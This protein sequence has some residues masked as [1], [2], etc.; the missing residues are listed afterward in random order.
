[1]RFILLYFGNKFEQGPDL[2]SLARLLV[3]FDLPI[4]PSGQE[5]PNLPFPTARWL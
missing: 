2:R 1:M 3:A 5:E 4:V